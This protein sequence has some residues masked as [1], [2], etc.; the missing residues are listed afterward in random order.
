M[1]VGKENHHPETRGKYRSWDTKAMEKGIAA[2]KAGMGVQGAA[3]KY[4]LP[5]GKNHKLELQR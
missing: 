5:R 4:D 3:R 1:P 2:C